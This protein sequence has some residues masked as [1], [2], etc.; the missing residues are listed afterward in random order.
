[1]RKIPSKLS[2][3]YQNLL[4]QSEN[5][6]LREESSRDQAPISVDPISTTPPVDEDAEAEEFVES[7]F[8]D[9]GDDDEADDAHEEAREEEHETKDDGQL[10]GELHHVNFGFSS[11]QPAANTRHR[12][13]ISEN[14]SAGMPPK[15]A[16]FQKLKCHVPRAWP[17]SNLWRE[18]NGP[19]SFDP[20]VLANQKRQW[21]QLQLNPIKTV[22]LCM[23]RLAFCNWV[24]VFV[25]ITDCIK[26]LQELNKYQ[27][28]TSFFEHFIVIGLHPYVNL[29]MVEDAFAKRKKREIEMEK[30]GMMNRSLMQYMNSLQP[31][32]EPQILFK[33]PPRKKLSLRSKDL[34]GFCFPGGVKARVMEKTPSLSDLNVHVHGQDHLGRDDSSFIFSLKV[35]NNAT[36][37]GVC[38]HVQEIVQRPPSLLGSSSPV[39]HPSGRLSRFLVS[40]PRCYCLLT[41]VPFFELHYQ[42]LNSLVALDRLNR[43]TEFINDMNNECLSSSTRLFET[44]NEV[45]SPCEEQ[46]TDWAASAIPIDSAVALAAAAAGILPD[47]DVPSSSS[48]CE[49]PSARSVSASETS[50][51]S[52]TR[53]LEKHDDYA[54]EAASETHSDCDN[55]QNQESIASNFYKDSGASDIHNLESVTSFWRRCR[56]SECLETSKIFSPARS[57]ASEDEDDETCSSHIREDED[58]MIMEWAREHK[59]ELL[60]IVSSYHSMPIPHRG[61]EIAILPLEHLQPFVYRRPLVSDLGLSQKF[62]EQ[63]I[64]K[65]LEVD[66]VN[67]KLATA[68]EAL[69]LSIWGTAT[70]CRVLSLENV[71]AFVAGVLLEKQ[72]IVVCPNLGILSAVIL[73]LIPMIR[74]FEWQSL[75]LPVLPGKM[76]DFIDAPVP[77]VVGLQHKPTDWKTK[78]S[79]LICINVAKNKVKAFNLPL[80]PRHK[81]LI[82]ELKPIHARLFCEKSTARRRPV[83]RCNETQ[84][85]AATQ[86]LTVMRSYLESLCSD[87]RNHTITSVRSNND[88][89]SILLKDSFID[90]FLSKDQAFVKLFVDTQLFSVLSDSHLSCYENLS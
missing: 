82:S 89:V 50:D 55:F 44:I 40:A 1:M 88:R 60:L 49:S 54:S 84:A 73:S 46:R 2:K 29:D 75:F 69:A 32:M 6:R 35:A 11:V 71:M 66:E 26:N 24:H 53:E 58:E 77:F 86:F 10:A 34:V 83:Y 13:S 14:V 90:S 63:M 74:P 41:S 20:E 31:T 57:L 39:S 80:L 47:D 15:N 17:W 61:N 27:E 23:R 56:M 52:Q 25:S 51:Y 65:K 18:Q 8:A 72:L 12:R 22:Y 64:Q 19:L 87:L 85:E 38:L 9:M 3:P 16:G 21:C 45:G 33:Y 5:L 79:N 62:L 68:E 70:I 37:Y 78:T 36:L 43:I 76:I 30:N 81:E 28:P 4:V 7:T 59:N 67:R 48:R 42:M